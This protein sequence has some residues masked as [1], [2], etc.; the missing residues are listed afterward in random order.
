MLIETLLDDQIEYGQNIDDLDKFNLKAYENS[1]SDDEA[2]F[3]NQN[4]NDNKFP[5][6]NIYHDIGPL[7]REFVKFRNEKDLRK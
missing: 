4:T 6:V 7:S 2:K 1:D 5:N 3:Q